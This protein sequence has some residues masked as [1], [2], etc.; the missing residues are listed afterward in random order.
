[1]SQSRL[2][3]DKYLADMGLGTRSEV[4]GMI[5]SGRI[6]VNGQRARSADIKIDPDED[7]VMCDQMPVTYV[8]YEY[9]MLNKPAGVISATEDRREKTVVDLIDANQ[10][11]DLF[12]VGRLDKDT[13]GLLLI[14]NDGQLAHQ[15]L[16]PK[17]HVA[18]VYYA[19]VAGTVTEEDADIF[20][21]GVVIDETLTALPAKLDIL[22]VT[23]KDCSPVS[24]IKIEIYEGKF[25][26]VKRMFEAVGKKVIYL[27][28]LS[29]G[30]L[31]LDETL[32]CG[33]YRKLSEDEIQMLKSSVGEK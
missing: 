13:E 3:L 2:R 31:C 19:K 8:H 12:P 27:K 26:Q 20:A 22:S 7:E 6:L 30:P 16:A 15:L 28:R 32:A 9:Y 24:E 23:D 14:T 29:M 4:K 21:N 17:K 25:H 11:K 5:R 1:M 10:R 33:Q 18:K